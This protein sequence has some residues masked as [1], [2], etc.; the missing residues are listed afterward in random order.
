MA[1]ARVAHVAVSDLGLR[2]HL[3]KQMVHLKALG[4]DVHAVT[5]PGRWISA[6]GPTEDG[7]PVKLARYTTSAATPIRD[8]RGLVELVRYFRAQRFD[9]VHTHGLKPGLLGR[10]AARIARVPVVVHTVYGLG[11]DVGM[12]ALERR[13]WTQVERLGMRLGDYALS[14]GREDLEAAIA[15]GI[16]PADRIGYLG[17]GVDL[18]VFNPGAV[19]RDAV[20]ALRLGVRPGEHVVCMARRF[21]PEPGSLEFFEAARLV[22]QQRGD[23][24]FWA[25]RAEPARQAGTLAAE[26]PLVAEASRFVRFLG[27]RRNMADV[28]AAADVFV[29][30]SHGR[31][32]LPRV[33]MEAA[34]MGRPIVATDGRGCR[35]VVQHGA[36]GL[37]VPAGDPEALAGAMLRLIDDREE[38]AR[39]GARAAAFA[40]AHFDE[41]EYCRT[42]AACYERLLG[43]ARAGGLAWSV[44]GSGSV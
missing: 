29:F 26:H 21:L 23:V 11:V 30:P 6:E 13:L 4:Y 3:R 18:T 12:S 8:A 1:I 33:L 43:A 2:V 16:C 24:Q 38:A 37:L 7:I 20:D 15:L 27:P 10:L 17:S 22:R 35:E 19:D 25:V 39:L 34:A 36:T 31:K 40:R 44:Q 14:Q 32:S 28:L 9:I 42:I 41:N 5:P